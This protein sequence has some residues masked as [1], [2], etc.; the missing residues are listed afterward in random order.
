MGEIWFLTLWGWGSDQS[1]PQS[2]SKEVQA[3]FNV[4][5]TT[6][7]LLFVFNYLRSSRS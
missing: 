1:S 4:P 3:E 7:V 6:T 2:S 5:S